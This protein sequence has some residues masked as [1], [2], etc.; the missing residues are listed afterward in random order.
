MFKCNSLIRNGI[1]NPGELK[2]EEIIADYNKRQK[3]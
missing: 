3:K 2:D 1:R